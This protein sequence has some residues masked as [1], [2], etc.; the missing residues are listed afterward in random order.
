VKGRLG[1]R[2]KKTFTPAV[3]DGRWQG[4]RALHAFCPCESL[5]D[6]EALAAALHLTEVGRWLKSSAGWERATGHIREHIAQVVA[7]H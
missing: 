7:V 4:K 3:L 5:Q 1:A 6:A 2:K